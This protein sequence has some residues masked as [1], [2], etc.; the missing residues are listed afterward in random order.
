[1]FDLFGAE[2]PLAVRFFLAFLIVLGLIGAAAWAVRRFG[3]ARLGGAVRGR[4]PRLAVI[5]YATVDARRRLLLVRRDNVEHLM[6]IG[7]PSDVVVESNIV[8]AVPAARE[9]VVPRAPA[10]ADTLSRAIPL[11]EAGSNGSWP[12]QPEPPAA[13]PAAPP[14]RAP[15][16]EQ[17]PEE[18]M[19]APPPHPEPPPRPQREVLSALADDLAAHAPPGPAPVTPLPPRNRR[20][21]RRDWRRPK[22]APSIARSRVAAP[23]PAVEPA[24]ADQSLAEMAQRL[25]AALRKPKTADTAR[26]CAC[27]VAEPQTSR[28]DVAAWPRLPRRPAPRARP[29]QN[30]RAPKPRPKERQ[31]ALRHPR[32][33]DGE[34]VGPSGK[35]KLMTSKWGRRVRVTTVAASV[36]ALIVSAT[37]LAAQDISINLGQG[38]AGGGLNE[39]IIQLIALLTVLSLAPS[40]LV[41]MTS[42]TRIV[43]VLSLLRTALGT[44][45]SPPNS[46]VIS[47]ALFLTAFVMGP[48]LT[49]VYDVGIKPLV[50]N[51]INVN[52]AFDRASGPLRGFMEK[53][54]REKDLRLFVDMSGEK[55]P[56]KP[57]D[58]SMRILIP[59]FMISELKR[60]FE[61]G[62]LLFLPFLII[63]L[64]VAS[65]LM[66]MGMM[67]LPP[68]VVSLPFK[69]IFFVLVDGWTLVAGSLIQSYGT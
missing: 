31:S 14:R 12:L 57:E 22:R 49:R 63:D 43:V 47:L 5:E 37:P 30:R 52:E 58:L 20:R 19:S 4:Q 65:V 68:V 64:V 9:P 53:N 23:Q 42:F 27:A 50:A 7:G 40:I 51:E 56:A 35:Q 59:A 17:I 29:K 62:F 1:M 13:V 11:P 24:A 32:T 33:G 60:A 69:L 55:A 15:R 41:M 2:M 16:I 18:Q 66:S 10:P 34:F 28:Q 6:M 21:H 54:V 61:I 3:S 45:T 39:R 38:T 67:M 8:R 48:V 36:A 44:A 25:E 46:V 26:P